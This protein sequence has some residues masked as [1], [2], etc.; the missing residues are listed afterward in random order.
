RPP[1]IL[2]IEDEPTIRRFYE[3]FCE[4]QGYESVLAATGSL[5]ME[6][7]DSGQVFDVILLDVR[8]PGVSGRA[9]WKMMELS[10]PELCSRVIMVTADILSESTRELIEQSG[11][12]YLEKPFSTQQLADVIEAVLRV[13]R[14]KPGH[15]RRMGS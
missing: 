12:P 3:R 6:I 11:R 7:I 15:G 2:V 8:L 10:R 13:P 1:K 9:L 4:A 5:A 14:E